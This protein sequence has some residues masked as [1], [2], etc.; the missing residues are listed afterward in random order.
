MQI[1]P[2][3]SMNFYG[4]NNVKQVVKKVQ[5]EISSKVQEVKPDF[6][7]YAYA[8]PVPAVDTAKAAEKTVKD[9]KAVEGYYPFG[10]STEV[11][12]TEDKLKDEKLH[13][14]YRVDPEQK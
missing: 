2:I 1:L 12:A 7:Q 11:K 5:P 13:E 8:V 6:T 4:K 14:Y 9:A 10:A 3:T